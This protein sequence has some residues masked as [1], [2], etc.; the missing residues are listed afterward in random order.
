MIPVDIDGHKCKSLVLSSTSRLFELLFEDVAIQFPRY[1]SFLLD[2]GLY[3][4]DSNGTKLLRMECPRGKGALLDELYYLDITPEAVI[5]TYLS[6]L[7][8]L[9]EVVKIREKLFPEYYVLDK[10]VQPTKIEIKD[11]PAGF[12]RGTFTLIDELITRNYRRIK[13][14]SPRKL[15][16]V[17]YDPLDAFGARVLGNTILLFDKSDFRELAFLHFKDYRIARTLFTHSTDSY[18]NSAFFGYLKFKVRKFL[19]V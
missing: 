16:R 4:V 6:A 7:F 13:M 17:R 1:K 5:E 14:G 19:G 2:R 10:V 8:N 12:G 18:L 3:I 11:H 15:T 9:L